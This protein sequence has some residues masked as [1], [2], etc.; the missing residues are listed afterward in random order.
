[1]RV[2]T[3]SQLIDLLRE[4]V[5]APG[6][7]RTGRGRIRPASPRAL[8]REMA[9]AKLL[10]IVI[11]LGAAIFYA[12]RR[13][14]RSFLIPT[15]DHRFAGRGRANNF[16]GN[17]TTPSFVNL[18]RDHFH[19]EGRGDGESTEMFQGAANF[20]R[21][22][23][24]RYAKKKLHPQP[25][26]NVT[27]TPE[28]RFFNRAIQYDFVGRNVSAV[29]PTFG[30]PEDA[31]CNFVAMSFDVSQQQ[32]EAELGKTTYVS[33]FRTTGQCGEL[34]GDS[35][36]FLWDPEKPITC[37]GNNFGGMLGPANLEECRKATPGGNLVEKWLEKNL[38]DDAPLTCLK[39]QIEI[40]GQVDVVDLMAIETAAL[41]S[42]QNGSRLRQEMQD[43]CLK[44]GFGS[45]QDWNEQLY[46]LWIG[47]VISESTPDADAAA[48]ILSDLSGVVDD[49]THASCV[50]GLMP[51]MSKSVDHNSTDYLLWKKWGFQV[52]RS[53]M[54]DSPTTLLRS[55]SDSL[56]GVLP[57]PPTMIYGQDAAV[58]QLVN[59][60]KEAYF[61]G[62]TAW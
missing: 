43:G 48:R 16:R 17:G 30:P 56:G 49:P 42:A 50:E 10:T 29:E 11:L 24:E 35:T 33:A 14:T 25:H 20:L 54:N 12:D 55:F 26:C 36:A 52:L 2:T 59:V 38:D 32:L 41:R 45:N 39:Q 51:R 8:I 13:V 31:A 6:N 53:T 37:L 46:T 7:G 57:P 62:C 19:Q 47:S 61:P 23:R 1:M 5:L 21:S 9:P 58:G 34:G 44:S 22:L 3:A 18:R 4:P 60:K 27:S 40:A 28:L 15:Y